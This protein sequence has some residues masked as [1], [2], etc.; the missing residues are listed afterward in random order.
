MRPVRRTP[1]ARTLPAGSAARAELRGGRRRRG[2]SRAGAG[3]ARSAGGEVDD[4][5]EVVAVVR[6]DVA[7]RRRRPSRPGAPG[8][9]PTAATISATARGER[10]RLAGGEHRA[11]ADELHEPHVVVA[12]R[13][14]PRCGRSRAM[15]AAT[16][17]P[18]SAAAIAVESTTSTNAIAYV[19]LVD[20][21]LAAEPCRWRARSAAGAS[22]RPR[23]RRPRTRASRRAR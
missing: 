8:A 18:S 14:R 19:E 15:R 10:R 3:R 13:P 7:E 9:R 21:D 6:G 16:C 20:A 22:R 1:S 4:L 17:P 5:P 11:V 23:R 2:G 12:P